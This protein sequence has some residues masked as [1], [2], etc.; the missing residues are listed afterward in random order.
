[1]D[2]EFAVSKPNRRK[3][4]ERERKAHR[5]VMSKQ[6]GEFPWNR[7]KSRKQRNREVAI[8]TK[9]ARYKGLPKRK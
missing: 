3:R 4:Q 7:Q 1:M 8:T 9:L 6:M 2:E 5:H